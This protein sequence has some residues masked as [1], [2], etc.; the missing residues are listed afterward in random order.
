MKSL[1]SLI[2]FHGCDQTVALKGASGEMDLLPSLNHY[3]WLGHGYYG[4]EDSEARAWQW[5]EEAAAKGRIHKPAVLGMVVDPGFC[6]NL[7][8]AGSLALVRHAYERYQNAC[9]ASGIK[10]ARNSGAG[11]KARY[12]DCAVFE[13]LQA[14]REMDGL[15]PFDTVRGFFVEGSELYPGA[16]LR[17]RDHIQICVRNPRCI[18]GYF[19]PR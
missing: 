11:F 4:W 10:M 9:H 6:L 15:T 2:A 12:L 13:H 17:D 8:D 14:S 18:K 19:L 7:V 1:S 5:A 16:G 3:D